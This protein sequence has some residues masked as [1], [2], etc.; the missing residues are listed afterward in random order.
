MDTVG[1]GTEMTETNTETVCI[2]KREAGAL[3]EFIESCLLD[4]IRKDV[5]IDSIAWVEALISVWRKCGGAYDDDEI[6]AYS[7]E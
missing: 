2:T 4:M 1:D 6:G 7:G 3:I 5:A